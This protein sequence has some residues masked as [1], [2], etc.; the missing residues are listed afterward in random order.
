VLNVRNEAN[1]EHGLNQR[2]FE[3]LAC[4][5]VVLN[6]DLADLPLCF[7]PGREILVYRDAEE[8]NALMARLRREPSLPCRSPRQA[9]SGCWP[10]IPMRIG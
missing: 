1:V 4:G 8:L 5:A 6:D 7:E 3:P 10:N 2:S 9:V